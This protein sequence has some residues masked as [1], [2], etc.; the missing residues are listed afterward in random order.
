MSPL[1]LTGDARRLDRQV[2]PTCSLEDAGDVAGWCGGR[3]RYHEA[4]RR[5]APRGEWQQEPTKAISRLY[6]SQDLVHLKNLPES[7]GI[8]YFFS[9]RMRF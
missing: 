5:S 8:I 6:L 7:R 4:R 9:G 2:A 3:V 1:I